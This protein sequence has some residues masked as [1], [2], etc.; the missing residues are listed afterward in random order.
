[1]FKTCGDPGFPPS[2]MEDG[3]MPGYL[4]HSDTLVIAQADICRRIHSISIE[5]DFGQLL[6]IT[7]WRLANVI[8]PARGSWNCHYQLL[9]TSYAQ[10][11]PGA[12]GR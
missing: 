7:P 12:H 9:R 4:D 6:T 1:M 11:R 5:R 3:H 8:C 10:P 2:K